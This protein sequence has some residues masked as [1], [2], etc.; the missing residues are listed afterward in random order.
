MTFAEQYGPWALIAGASEG[1]GSAFA[2]QVAA[3]GINCFLVARRAGPLD[4]LASELRSQYQIECRTASVDLS[5][6]DASAR[7]AKL[8]ADSE[9]GLFINNAGSDTNGT[10]FLDTALQ[11]SESLVARNVTN[12]M[13]NCH[14]FAGL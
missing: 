12:T 11:D 1:T 13:R 2:R 9:I 8:T 7:L 6:D 10:L 3:A 5:A 14:H 4:T